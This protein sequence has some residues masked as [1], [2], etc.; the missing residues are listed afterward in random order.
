MERK[1]YL[2]LSLRDEYFY[3]TEDVESA[4]DELLGLLYA[5]MGKGYYDNRSLI[6]AIELTSYFKG[7]LESKATNYKVAYEKK[8]SDE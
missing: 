3:Q 2:K 1:E 7:H 5:E 8:E 4:F 6:K